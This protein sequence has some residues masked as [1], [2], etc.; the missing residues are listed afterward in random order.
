MINKR[1]KTSPL[2]STP[3]LS[4]A[5]ALVAWEFPLNSLDRTNPTKIVFQF[6]KNP[7]LEAAVQAFW[8]N[9]DTVY[10]KIYFNALREVK[11]RIYG[12]Q[13]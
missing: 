1:F 2:F 8:D 11:S 12:G 7:K 5:A 9:T 3:E 6:F 10:P 13:E 4:L